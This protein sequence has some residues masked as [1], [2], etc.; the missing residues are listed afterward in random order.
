MIVLS[1]CPLIIN[2]LTTVYNGLSEM[3]LHDSNIPFFF[4]KKKVVSQCYT[5]I[6]GER[7][8]LERNESFIN[9]IFLLF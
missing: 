6:H 5:H 1:G 7:W 4:L 2:N 8:R 9:T 3:F